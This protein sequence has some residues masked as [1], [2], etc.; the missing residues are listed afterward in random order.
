MYRTG[1]VWAEPDVG[2]AARWMRVVA[3][4]PELGRN[5]GEAGR[6]TIR[7]RFSAAQ[8]VDIV[9]SRLLDGVRLVSES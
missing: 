9:K 2:Q 4:D 1:S 8:V 3:R 6:A 7:E 5:I